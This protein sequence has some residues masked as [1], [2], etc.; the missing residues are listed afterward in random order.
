MQD[1][2]L[3]ILLEARDWMTAGDVADKGGY[4]SAGNVGVCLKNLGDR[5]VSRKSPTRKQ[6][7]G[8]PAVEWRHADNFFEQELPVAAAKALEKNGTAMPEKATV[9]K[10][11]T[12]EMPTD[13][14]CCNAAKVVATTAG[15]EVAALNDIITT[16]NFEI[17]ALEKKLRTETQ[18][19][20]AAEVNRDDLK[21]TLSSS[22][23]ANKEWLKLAGEFECKSAPELRVFINALVDRA[24][25][26]K[27]EA[28]PKKPAQPRRPFSV[29]GLT[30]YHAGGEKVTLFLDRRLSARSIT[31]PSDKLHQLADMA[32][33]AA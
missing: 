19:A 9:R 3:N 23:S 5:V 27:K 30:G 26:L 8:M 28:K 17:E 15:A 33:E 31:L 7:N 21:Q 18:R 16:R 22:V 32:K 24:E 20:E 2:V 1:K 10:S 14:E 6:L 29:T 4:R 25:K 12:V 11:R 13:K